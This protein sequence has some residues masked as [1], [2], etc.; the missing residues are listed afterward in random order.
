[1]LGVEISPRSWGVLGSASG[2]G[3][4]MS[5][6][7][8]RILTLS[9]SCEVAAGSVQ[10]LTGGMRIMELCRG[11]DST[12]RIVCVGAR[13]I[14]AA[15]SAMPSSGAA[16]AVSTKSVFSWWIDFTNGFC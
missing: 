7:G 11:F 1:M 9:S 4:R 14:A 6:T 2:E 5:G 3:F 12:S 16:T 8:A 10:V 15:A 13:T